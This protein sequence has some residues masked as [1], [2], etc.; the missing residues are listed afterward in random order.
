MTNDMNAAGVRFLT[1]E[2]LSSQSIEELYTLYANYKAA[3]FAATEGL[4]KIEAEI[5]RRYLR[6]QGHDL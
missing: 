1:P 5:G 3:S 2:L 6:E 4:R